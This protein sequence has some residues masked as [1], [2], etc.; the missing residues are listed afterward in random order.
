MQEQ[1]KQMKLQ[2]MLPGQDKDEKNPVLSEYLVKLGGFVE[3]HFKSSP[4]SSIHPPAANLQLGTLKQMNQLAELH[5][6]KNLQKTKKIKQ[7]VSETKEQCEAHQSFHISDK[8]LLL[9]LTKIDQ[10]GQ[11]IEGME[12]NVDYLEMIIDRIG[13]AFAVS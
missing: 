8:K 13:R 5:Y 10:I 11:Y 9:Y 12:Q 6:T 7:E 3:N 4:F 2:K 1:E